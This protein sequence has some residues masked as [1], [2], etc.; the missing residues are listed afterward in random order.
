MRM[1]HVLRG[2]VRVPFFTGLVIVTLALGIAANTA[3]FSVIQAVLL[4]PLPFHDPEQLVS[5]DHRAPGVNIE[6]AGS[7]AFLYFT[8]REDAKSFQDVG[9]WGGDTFSV[10]GAGE[11]EEVRGMDVTD[12]VFPMLG[13]Q[14]A[15]GRLFDRKDDSPDGPET[16]VL[17]YQYWQTRF[18]GDRAALGRRIILDGRPR[19]IIG[20]LPQSFRFLDQHPSVVV[21]LRLNRKDTH[22]G[23][24]NFAGIARLKPGVALEQANADLS[25]LIPVALSRFPAFPGYNAKMFETAKLAP[26]VQPLAM[27]ETGD[28]STVLWVLMG[29]VGLVLLIACANVANLMLVR[30]D[31]RQQELA[32]RAALGASRGRI[33]RELLVESVLLGAVGGTVGVALAYGALRLLKALAPANLP[34]LDQIAIDGTVLLFTLVISLGAGLL[35]G[36]MPALRHAGLHVTATLRAGGRA[37]SESR[38]RRRARSTLVVIQVALA[39]VL[40]VSSGLMI[41]TF[42]ALRHVTPGFSQPEHIQTLRLFIPESQIEKPLAVLQAEEQ[43]ASQI[44]AVPGVSSVAMTTVIPMDGGGWHD[45]IFAADRTYAESDIPPIRLFKFTSPGLVKT[46]GGTLIAGRDFTWTDAYEKRMVAMVSENLARELWQSPSAALGKRIRENLKGQWREV[47]GVVGDER[48]DGVNQKAPATVYWPLMMANFTGDETAVRRGLSYVIRSDRAGS[49]A[50]VG[51]ISKA[52]WSVNPNLPV[53][54]VRTLQEV[55]DRSLATTSFTLVMLAIAGAMALLL[56]VS[57]IYGVISYSVAQRTREIGIRMALGA[58]AQEVRAMFLR[59]GFRLAALGIACGLVV[60]IASTRLM[61]SLLFETSPLDP[62]TYLAVSIGLVVA[63][64]LASYAPAA[65]ATAVNPVDSLRAE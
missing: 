31:G 1:T 52:V 62:V 22:L 24:F 28:I 23:Q 46:V 21:P 27:S 48:T 33:V 36:I 19:E 44:G 34:R 37:L 18:G 49:S 39:L 17:S 55:Y 4:K 12:G 5:V 58:Q 11:P 20:V 10:T 41:R 51:E 53:A 25:R 47:V 40:L 50:F 7:A 38:E 54:S 65:R 57:G 30:A 26:I 64:A 61:A 43:I 8:Y 13:V 16:V 59:Y 15:V 60:A 56:G 9:M 2:L 3:I 6:H 42:Q 63:A 29:T 45:P 32:V 14:P 35:F